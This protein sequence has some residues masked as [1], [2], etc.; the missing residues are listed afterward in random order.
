MPR[1]SETADRAGWLGFPAGHPA[2]LGVFARHRYLENWD[3]AWGTRGGRDGEA[4]EFVF[5]P[6]LFYTFNPA[7]E[8]REL[9]DQ[10]SSEMIRFWELGIPAQPFGSFCDSWDRCGGFYPDNHQ[11]AWFPPSRTIE[12]FEAWQATDRQLPVVGEMVLVSRE[13]VPGLNRTGY[14]RRPEIPYVVCLVKSLEG[15]KAQTIIRT[16]IGDGVIDAEVRILD[17]TF[18]L[19]R[20]PSKDPKNRALR[21]Q[22]TGKPCGPGTRIK[23]F[24][25]EDGSQWAMAYEGG[26]SL[27]NDTRGC[28]SCGAIYWHGG[29]QTYCPSCRNSM[30]HC[31]ICGNHRHSSLISEGIDGNSVCEECRKAG[32]YIGLMA[33]DYRPRQFVMHKTPSESEITS[34]FF[35]ME[36]EMDTE[37]W[38]A[39]DRS[40]RYLREMMPMFH[41]TKGEVFFVKRDGSLKKGLEWVFHPHT[42]A[43]IEARM[44]KIREMLTIVRREGMRSHDTT[45]CGFHIHVGRNA[46][47]ETKAAQNYASERLIALTEIFQ[48]NII[49]FSR[50][51]KT[52]L[53]RYA[54]PYLD[55]DDPE[56]G[57]LRKIESS[58]VNNGERG[59]DARYK[60]IN[61]RNAQTIEFRFFR[62][63]LVWKTI[64]ACIYLTDNL[65]KLS[66]DFT[67]PIEKVTWED[68][69]NL[70]DIEILKTY[71][72]TRKD[73]KIIERVS[74][75][76]AYDEELPTKE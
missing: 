4:P 5:D 54:S 2:L 29:V 53:L 52:G 11:Y 72:D 69:I 3:P 47:G 70:G 9:S 21:D 76:P 74:D 44:P 15:T 36:F 48:L 39:R 32:R 46:F 7:G 34:T 19:E 45:T 42:L 66:R 20:C 41:G 1:I 63:T 23:T 17:I 65:V 16:G 51:N 49:K 28:D 22:Y 31:D 67:I 30:A 13:K 6:N 35:G 68:I 62:G 57:S 8:T 25:S 75:E 10:W 38:N 43:M 59:H 55:M 26:S 14:Y 33:H 40:A 12:R 58:V 73:T 61:V 71:W 18:V 60:G 37:D 50:R 64:M 24:C 27:P 56:R